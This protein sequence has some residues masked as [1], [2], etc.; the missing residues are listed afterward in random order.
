MGDQATKQ[1]VDQLISMAENGNHPLIG[2][3][4]KVTMKTCDAL[5][6]NNRKYGFMEGMWWGQ[7]W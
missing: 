6:Y 1:V 5:V 2:T 3:F 7:R 4:L